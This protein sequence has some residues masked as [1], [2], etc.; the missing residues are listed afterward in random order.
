MRL[1]V[2][3]DL[4]KAVTRDPALSRGEMR[5]GEYAARIQEGFTKTGRPRYVYFKTLE[6]R[7]NYLK[8]K[9]KGKEEDIGEKLSHKRDK[10]RQKAKED[11][12]SASGRLTIGH[13][14][15]GKDKE[16]EKKKA[17]GKD[18]DVSKSFDLFVFLED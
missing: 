14:V 7:D 5:G 1:F 9:Q 3:T 16:E 11:M 10:E 13:I 8:N 18:K 2:R 6:Q 12:Q 15:D 17:K 4:T